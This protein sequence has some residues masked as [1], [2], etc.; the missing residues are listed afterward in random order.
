MESEADCRNSCN[1]NCLNN[2]EGDVYFPNR[3]WRKDL[4]MLTGELHESLS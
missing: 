1:F 2:M 3:A 4:S